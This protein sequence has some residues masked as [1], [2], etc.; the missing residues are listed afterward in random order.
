MSVMEIRNLISKHVLAMMSVKIRVFDICQEI[1]P[2][3]I[4]WHSY[5][6]VNAKFQQK[7]CVDIEI[8]ANQN[9]NNKHLLAMM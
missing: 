4:P 2:G 1:P 5:K 9:F 6:N 7:S 8:V 3:G